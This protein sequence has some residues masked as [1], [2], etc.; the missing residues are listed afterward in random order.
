MVLESL[1]RRRQL[2][3][4]KARRQSSS[5]PS[6]LD[7]RLAL[8]LSI[9]QDPAVQNLLRSGRIS[10]ALGLVGSANPQLSLVQLR[11]IE[12]QLRHEA[13]HVGRDTQAPRQPPADLPDPGSDLPA[14]QV[15]SDT[16]R[17]AM[18]HHGYLIIRGL[19]DGETAGQARGLIDRALDPNSGAAFHSP[20]RRLGEFTAVSARF[21]KNASTVF[22]GQANALD[23][24]AAADWVLDAYARSGIL[25]WVEEYLGTRP[26][27]ALEKW[28]LRKVPPSNNSSWHQ[29]GAFLGAEVNTIN[30]WIAL[31]DCGV[32]AP[33]LDL[34]DRRF[35]HVLPTGTEGAFF[36]WDI[37]PDVVASER[38]DSPI[39]TPVF[40][41]GDAI[42]F[43]QFLVHRTGVS[44]TMTLPRYAL[45]SWFFSP[46]TVPG[47]YSG[48]LI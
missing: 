19:F 18:A 48:V 3:E 23:A 41:P 1:N 12:F 14:H 45:E 8:E 31:S 6:A 2:R 16:V 26:A 42:V 20:L 27:L 5:S 34:V 17:A 40:A 13:L 11:Q 29:D 37:S 44:P 4:Y 38:G 39:I 15:S 33:G 46:D 22:D 7:S 43:D 21:R 10:D 35:R 9:R 24:P 32:D 28:T 36:D 47:H 25:R 30:T